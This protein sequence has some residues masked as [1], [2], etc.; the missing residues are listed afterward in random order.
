MWS[1]GSFLKAAPLR[2]ADGELQATIT[3]TIIE[4]VAEQHQAE[5]FRAFLV[6][7]GEALS[8]SLDYEQT[9]R[10]VAQ[11]AVPEIADWCAVDLLG[12]SG[13][14]I[15]VGV[16]HTDPQKL[17]L[18]EELRAYEPSVLNADRG[19]GR[20]LRTGESILYPEVPDELLVRAPADEQH[21]A[22]IRSVGM[23]SVLIVPMRIADQ[24]L[25]A[26]TLINAE[27]GR[28]LGERELQLAT[29][30]A[31]RAAVAIENSRLYTQR[32]QIAHTL[33]QTLLPRV[34]PGD[35][36]L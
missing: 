24:T 33:Q 7:A 11:L 17:T 29:Q 6:A 10:T 36:R 19:V 27:S 22:L 2:G 5:R 1:S 32:S 21:L 14:R 8:S 12:P 18:A 20:V 25:G 31:A 13:E 9:L 15:P 23:R 3:I 16:A 34:L 4:N 35:P 26:M 30:L 28:T